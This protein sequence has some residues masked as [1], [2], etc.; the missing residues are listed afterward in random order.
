MAVSTAGLRKSP[1]GNWLSGSGM[2]QPFE[3]NSAVQMTSMSMTSYSSLLAWRFATSWA[4]W[5]LD[6]SGSSS[7]VTFWL[8][9]CLFQPVITPCS[10]PELSLPMA[11]VIGPIPLVDGA[12]PARRGAA[13]GA[14]GG[15]QSPAATTAIPG[16]ARLIRA[17]TARSYRIRTCMLCTAVRYMSTGSHNESDMFP[18]RPRGDGRRNRPGGPSPAAPSFAR[19]RPYLG[20]MHSDNLSAGPRGPMEVT[21]SCGSP[22]WHCSQKS[23]LMVTS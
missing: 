15:E 19:A 4:S 13:R 11:K 7:R 22:C 2:I 12:W 5:S 14:P 16:I 1:S 17:S 6:A 20:V 21:G 10:Q 9:F 18:P 23:R 8:G 3:A